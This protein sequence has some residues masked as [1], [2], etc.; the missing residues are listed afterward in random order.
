MADRNSRKKPYHHPI[1]SVTPEEEHEN[2]RVTRRYSVELAR[3]AL[4]EVEAANHKL[5]RLLHD[6][7]VPGDKW[8]DTPWEID[9]SLALLKLMLVAYDKDLRSASPNH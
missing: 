2:L 5:R 6:A 4:A 8:M 3:E 9:T 7:L 1:P